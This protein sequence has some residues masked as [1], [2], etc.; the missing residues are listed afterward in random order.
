LKELIKHIYHKHKGYGYRITDELNNQGVVI[1]HKTI[2]RLMKSSL[3]SVIRVKK[4][5]SYKENKERLLLIYYK[6]I[7]KAA[8]NQNGQLILQNLMSLV[9][10]VFISYY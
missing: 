4:Y 7:L 3:K 6:E 8:A 2:L 1:N 10:V 9:K 5:K